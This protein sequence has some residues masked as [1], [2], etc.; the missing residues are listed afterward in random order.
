ML[1]TKSYKQKYLADDQK[2]YR[3]LTAKEVAQAVLAFAGLPAMLRTEF[4]SS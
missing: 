4:G 1:G 2:T 3:K